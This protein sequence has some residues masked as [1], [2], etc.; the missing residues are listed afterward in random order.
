MLF[1]AHWL[2]LLQDTWD[3]FVYIFRVN[4]HKVRQFVYIRV[5]QAFCKHQQIRIVN[6][7]PLEGECYKC[8]KKVRL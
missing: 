6:H 7:W 3:K 1:I 5:K 8:G 4:V 2:D